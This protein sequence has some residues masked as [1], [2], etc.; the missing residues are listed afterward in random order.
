MRGELHGAVSAGRIGFNGG[1]SGGQCETGHSC[2]PIV[3]VC[4]LASYDQRVA[5]ILVTGV[6]FD[7]KARVAR[8]ARGTI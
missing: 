8:N 4:Q 2:L 1:L 5:L 3:D 7:A 6:C